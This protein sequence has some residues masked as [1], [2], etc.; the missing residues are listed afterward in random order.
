MPFFTMLML[1]GAGILSGI[2]N[3]VAGGGTFFTF[4]VLMAAGLPPVV[5]NASN[6][7]AVWPGHAL[8]LI[9]Y[10][11][12]ISEAKTNLTGSIVTVLA[13]GVLGAFLMIMAGNQGFSKLIPF[14]I[15]FATILFANGQRFYKWLNTHEDST[16][17]SPAL[18]RLIEFVIAVY[19][20]FF[21]AGLG[22]MFMAGLLMLGVTDIQMNNALKNLLGMLV[23]TIALLIFILSGLVS[24]PHTIVTF[25]GAIL[26]GFWGG[27][28]ARILPEL[29][30]RWT[31]I[32]VGSGLT[33]YYFFKYY[34]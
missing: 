11:D 21:S 20:G 32:S 29:W 7:V 34:L 16:H 1:F 23:T 3:A 8:A 14:L 12:Q 15:L 10:R 24:W 22:I 9:S 17:L 25:A 33:F 5:A 13:G 2:C 4:P 31:V 6:T 19:G 26:G 18:V 28:I 30:L 27:R